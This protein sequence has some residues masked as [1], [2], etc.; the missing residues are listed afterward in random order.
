[1][2]DT[3]FSSGLCPVVGAPWQTSHRFSCVI[4]NSGDSSHLVTYQESHSPWVP[5]H[6]LAKILTSTLCHPYM[7]P[8][9]HHIRRTFQLS[10]IL[11][12]H[13]IHKVYQVIHISCNVNLYLLEPLFF[14]ELATL[15]FS[16]PHQMLTMYNSNKWLLYL[17]LA[18][19]HLCP[20]LQEKQYCRHYAI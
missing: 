10:P 3:K 4:F 15:N 12:K 17:I 1:M 2:I 9:H 11:N 19:V 16:V 14:R 6:H 13:K 18:A 20:G 5:P 7:P 8:L